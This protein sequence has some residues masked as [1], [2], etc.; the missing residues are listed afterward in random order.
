M[1]LWEYNSSK[2][3]NITRI[4]MNAITFCKQSFSIHSDWCKAGTSVSIVAQE[5]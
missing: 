4:L 3:A 5:E 1:F 2:Q